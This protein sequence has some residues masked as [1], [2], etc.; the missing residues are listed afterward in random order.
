MG[1]GRCFGT[2]GE[3]EYPCILKPELGTFGPSAQ[4]DVHPGFM[5]FRLRL[6]HVFF[7]GVPC[8][9]VEKLPLCEYV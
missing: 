3:A 2:A 9:H 8:E 7:G 6:R 4:T 5:W 1:T